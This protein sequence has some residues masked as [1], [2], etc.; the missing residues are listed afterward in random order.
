M[1]CS[2]CGVYEGEDYM[3]KMP[4]GIA[5][6]RYLCINCAQGFFDFVVEVK[7][8]WEEEIRRRNNE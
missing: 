7:K 6:N 4:D 3:I 8:M 2:K 1:I 5:K